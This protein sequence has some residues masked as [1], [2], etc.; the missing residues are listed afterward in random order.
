MS[1]GRNAIRGLARLPETDVVALKRLSGQ[2]KSFAAGEQLFQPGDE[3][4]HALLLTH[5]RLAVKLPG[6][7]GV[8]ADMWPGEIVGESALV[9]GAHRGDAMVTAVVPCK[10]VVIT[11]QLI[12]DYSSDP[13]VVA[14]QVHLISVLSRRIHAS[15]RA[16]RLA[17][18]PPRAEEPAEETILDR[19]KRFFQE[20][21][22]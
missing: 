14:M 17:A 6:V 3:A 22:S 11:P 8:V 20:A 1:F 2:E 5:G 19:F 7:E 4:D 10:A 15:N 9:E 18:N 16:I 21:L 13:A 12:D